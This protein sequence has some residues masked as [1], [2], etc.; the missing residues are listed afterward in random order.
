MTYSEITWD[1]GTKVDTTISLNEVTGTSSSSHVQS[2]SQ[3][4]VGSS[5]QWTQTNGAGVTGIGIDPFASGYTQVEFGFHWDNGQSKWKI[6]ESGTK[7]HEQ[8]GTYSDTLTITI[9]TANQFKY[10]VN[11]VQAYISSESYDEDYTHYA[12]A[13]EINSQTVT[14]N[15]QGATNEGGQSVN[16]NEGTLPMDY[17][18][19]LNTRVPK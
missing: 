15:V 13:S 19:Y 11:G 18:L 2:T 8:S 5:I 17:I 3:L 7:V 1:A 16:Q 14:M 12:H 4:G 6:Y 9:T 10:S